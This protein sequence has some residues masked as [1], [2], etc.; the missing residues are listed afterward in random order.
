MNSPKTERDCGAYD[1]IARFYDDDMGRSGPQGDVR[2][3]V[4][5]ARRSGGPV[6]ELGCGTGRITLPIAKAGCHVTG[7]DAS[8]PMLDQLARKAAAELTPDGLQH[9]TLVR[10]DVRDF[11][12]NTSFNLILCPYSLI[13]YLVDRADRAA[14]LDNVRNLLR[15][16]GSFILDL[17]VQHYATLLLPD[18]YVFHDY[19]RVMDDGTI[20]EREKTIR[21]DLDRQ[22]N[23][24]SRTYRILSSEGALVET[25]TTQERIRYFFRG[26]IHQLLAEHRL[27][28]SE[29]YGGFDGEP[30]DYQAKTMVFVAVLT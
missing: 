20:L 7:V 1:R 4:E 16:G 5:R 18:D 23:I 29:E 15:P 8:Q 6:L 14:V 3:Y 10:A 2:F 24:I 26:E 12:G 19:R 21:K 30:F 9:L 25:F 13:T 22:I 11:I 27:A 17:F 28:V